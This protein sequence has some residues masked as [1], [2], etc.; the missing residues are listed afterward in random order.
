MKKAKILIAL[1]LG[2]IMLFA[3]TSTALAAF[4]PSGSNPTLSSTPPL[5]MPSIVGG[6]APAVVVGPEAP[7]Y[8]LPEVPYGQPRTPDGDTATPMAMLPQTANTT[9][10]LP[11]LLLLL[12]SGAVLTVSGVAYKREYAM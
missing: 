10:W 6:G 5:G 3:F 4:S 1:A 7:P 2:A 11:L 12:V 8:G 9:N